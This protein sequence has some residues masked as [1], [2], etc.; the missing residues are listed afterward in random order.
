MAAAKSGMRRRGFIVVLAVS[1]ACFR[2]RKNNNP[3]LPKPAQG[4]PRL[5][6]LQIYF[7]ILEQ[8]VIQFCCAFASAKLMPQT[9]LAAAVIVVLTRAVNP[10]AGTGTA[11][12]NKTV[13][14][15]I[16]LN[17]DSRCTLLG[18]TF[19]AVFHWK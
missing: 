4:K 13:R 17:E 8:V 9:V 10:A 7:R 14:V 19:L 2:R 3:N 5:Q 18:Q 15:N 16:I 1:C 12:A 11:G 6:D